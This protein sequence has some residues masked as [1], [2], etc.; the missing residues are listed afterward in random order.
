MTTLY[1][2]FHEGEADITSLP[3][4][5]QSRAVSSF[6]THSSARF[7]IVSHMQANQSRVW[8]NIPLTPSSQYADTRLNSNNVVLNNSDRRSFD[9]RRTQT[10]RDSIQPAASIQYCD[11][12]SHP[13]TMDIIV[14]KWGITC[15]GETKPV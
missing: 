7:E 5:F 14:K 6:P 12:R 4:D 3:L 11:P 15:S 2:T 13:N 8:E 10:N 1:E 9:Q